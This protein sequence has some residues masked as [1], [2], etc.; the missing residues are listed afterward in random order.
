MYYLDELF[1]RADIQQIR[2]FLL[3][4]VEGSVDPRSYRERIDRAQESVIS[5]L[6]E[7]YPDEREFE[8]LAELVYAY[9]SAVE[10]VALEIGLQAGAILVAQV[11]QNLRTAFQGK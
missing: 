8:E 3:N 7:K 11:F 4:G 10:E 2:E 6:N 1:R 9:G 5:R